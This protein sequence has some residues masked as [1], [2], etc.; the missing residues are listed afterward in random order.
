[1]RWVPRALAVFFLWAFGAQGFS[2][3]QIGEPLPDAEMPALGGGKDHLFT[4]AAA[5]VFFF[6]K[7]GQ[8]HSQAT[9]K[10]IAQ[11]AK[12]FA[13]KPVRWVGIISDRADTDRAIRDLKEADLGVPVLIDTND[14]FYGQLGV[15]LTPVIG[16]VGSD[17]R[18]AAYEPFTKVNYSN[19]LRARIRF[20]LKE[21]TAAELAEALRPGE[22]KD[23]SE[24]QVAHRW[25]RLAE[26][27]FAASNYDRALEN[28][29]TSF[30]H[31]TNLV[32]AHV[33][34][35]RALSAQGKKTEAAQCFEQAL[36]LEPANSAALDGLK[37]IG[38]RE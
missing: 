2:H 5:N 6:F 35:G 10:Q 21:I 26:R 31:D 20:L 23:D 16:I 18:L 25:L 32:P 17:D 38:H 13:A 7:P 15:A 11:C 22:L 19:I 24:T 14:V 3:A 1:M 12:D 33:L 4:N 37:A 30:S 8:E 28:V 27:A 36:R 29:R 34:M 9:L